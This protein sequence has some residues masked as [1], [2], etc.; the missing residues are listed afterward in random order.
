[1]NIGEAQAKCVDAVWEQVGRRE[2][3]M[4]VP[5]IVLHYSHQSSI[6][7]EYVRIPD[8]NHPVK[9]EPPVIHTPVVLTGIFFI[10]YPVI[11]FGVEVYRVHVAYD[12]CHLEPVCVHSSYGVNASKNAWHVVSLM[13]STSETLAPRLREVPRISIIQHRLQNNA[14]AHRTCL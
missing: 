8:L 3:D 6:I 14:R 7:F 13:A 10:P 5:Q 11:E 12:R 9:A 4:L 2:C 1:M